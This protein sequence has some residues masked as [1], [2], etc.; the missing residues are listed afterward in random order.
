MGKNTINVSDQTF[1]AEV[2]E[3]EVPVLVDFWAEWCGPCKMI[4]PMI[5][6]FAAENAGKIKVCKLD[7]EQGPQTASEYGVMNIPTIMFFKGGEVKDKVIGVVS[8]GD[9]TARISE[10]I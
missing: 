4:A 7:V 10:H 2:L 5:D 8:K 9:L 6:E 3:S 1:K